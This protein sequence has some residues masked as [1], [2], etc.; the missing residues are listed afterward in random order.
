MG[1]GSGLAGLELRCPRPR[2]PNESH[3]ADAGQPL[4]ERQPPGFEHWGVA[5]LLSLLQQL[6]AIPEAAGTS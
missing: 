6:G 1:Q 5:D 3:N 2:K 4:C